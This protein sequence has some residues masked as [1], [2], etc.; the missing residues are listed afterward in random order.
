MP[1]EYQYHTFNT[2][3]YCNQLITME[4]DLIKFWPSRDKF[5]ATETPKELI[6]FYHKDCLIE[7]YV[8]EER[9][10]VSQT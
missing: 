9:R 10:K 7:E 1:L 4:Q 8:Q 6:K 5:G 3:H 2:C